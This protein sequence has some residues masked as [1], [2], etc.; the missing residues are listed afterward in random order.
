M[1]KI[2]TGF[3]LVCCISS[4]SDKIYYSTNWQSKPVTIDG[5]LSEWSNPLRFYDQ[6]SGINY[7]IANDNHN[8]YFC[9]SISNE[10]LQTKILRSGLEFGIDTLGKKSFPVAIKFPAG[11]S[12]VP[13]LMRNSNSTPASGTTARPDRSTFRLK[14]LAE[15]TEIELTGFKSSIGKIIILTKPDN[16]GI[17]AAINFDQKGIMNYEAVIPFSAFYKKELIPSDSNT[18][19]NYQI[20]VK[21]VPGSTGGESGHGGGMRS[22]SGGGMGGGGGMRGGGGG[23]HGGGGG[24][25]GGGMGGGGTRGE[26]TS[27]EYQGQKGASMSSM[28]KTSIKLKLAYKTSSYK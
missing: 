20:R 27:N 21:P 3:L 7:T 28:T 24:M 8:L 11:N 23:M 4:C 14:L 22:G 5:K 15:A 18:V 16:S 1:N 10:S 17:S 19:F 9:C 13:D 2:I 6:E 25:H 12:Q 26:G